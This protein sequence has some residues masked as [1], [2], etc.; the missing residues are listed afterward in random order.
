MVI[1]LQTKNI[2]ERIK[3]TAGPKFITIF[4]LLIVWALI[5]P[6]ATNP[7]N[8]NARIP[9][10]PPMAFPNL[11]EKEMQTT[12]VNF[13]IEIR[14]SNARTLLCTYPEKSVAEICSLCGF[15]S[16]SYFGKVFK[17]VMNMSPNE[18]RARNI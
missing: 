16:P 17:K 12:I 2:A 8:P 10:E 6:F 4:M 13:L 15:Q 18:Y 14:I 1:P 11:V 9:I 7:T 3:N 5:S